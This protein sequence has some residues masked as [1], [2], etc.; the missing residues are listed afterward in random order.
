MKEW[1]RRKEKNI[2]TS[3][4]REIA[5]GLW[6]KCYGCQEV[7]YKNTL[8]S[9]MYVCSECMYH[10]RMPCNQYINMLMEK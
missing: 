9:N 10:F 8:I 6:V 2:T 3:N 1:F 4:R 7:I 5:E